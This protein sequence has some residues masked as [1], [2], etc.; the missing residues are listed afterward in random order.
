MSSMSVEN[1]FAALANGLPNEVMH[2]THALSVHDLWVWSKGSIEAHLG[3][4]KT[5]S[6]RMAFVT[7][8]HN[9]AAYTHATHPADVSALISWLI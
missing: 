6:S 5:D 3:I 9:T 1:A 7:T 4:Q 2:L 8:L